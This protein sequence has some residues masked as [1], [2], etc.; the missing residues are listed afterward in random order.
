MRPIKFKGNRVYIDRAKLNEGAAE[1]LAKHIAIG[2]Y[3]HESTSDTI[4][5]YVLSDKCPFR[6][7]D[8]SKEELGIGQ[9]CA[10]LAKLAA[11]R[12]FEQFCQGVDELAYVYKSIGLGSTDF[13]SAMA[14]IEAKASRQSG[15]A[16]LPYEIRKHLELARQ[17]RAG[18]IIVM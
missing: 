6:K 13:V 5:V 15:N 3:V 1:R 11:D 12:Q 8:A 10:E 18:S 2:W 17:K 7:R 16:L 14:R 4:E 9:L